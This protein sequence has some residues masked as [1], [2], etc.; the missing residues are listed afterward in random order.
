MSF[1]IIYYEKITVFYANK[2]I[3]LYPEMDTSL[4]THINTISLNTYQQIKPK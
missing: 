3:H 4:K 1:G 2:V